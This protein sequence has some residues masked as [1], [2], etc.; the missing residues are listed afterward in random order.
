MGASESQFDWLMCPINRMG[1]FS[2]N[3]KIV[4]RDFGSG[5]TYVIETVSS[6]KSDVLRARFHLGKGGGASTSMALPRDK[7]GATLEFPDTYRFYAKHCFRITTTEGH[8]YLLQV[9]SSLDDRT[10]EWVELDVEDNLSAQTLAHKFNTQ[11]G[12]QGGGFIFVCKPKAVEITQSHLP[13]IL[14]EG[15]AALIFPY[16]GD[17][18]EM[19]KFVFNA[20]TDREVDLP[21]AFFHYSLF[22]TQGREMVYDLQGEI[23]DNGDLFLLDPLVLSG[24]FNTDMIGCGPILGA[25]GPP[26]AF[27]AL[28]PRC[29][30]LCRLFDPV[31]KVRTNA[32]GMPFH[33]GGCNV[34]PL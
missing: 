31:R 8:Q 7:K 27:D 24:G 3:D 17:L 1:S 2:D 33:C 29:S 18:S 4:L 11:L 26:G 28:H 25:G 34:M 9:S 21:G 5:D 19:Q 14:S 30:P 16:K 20:E 12:E 15:D 10:R 6:M 22:I 32:G 23:D 13:A